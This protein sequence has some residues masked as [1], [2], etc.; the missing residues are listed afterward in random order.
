MHHADIGLLADLDSDAFEQRRR[1]V[2][3]RQQAQRLVGEYVAHR[4]VRFARTAPVGGQA[5][6]PVV[7]LGIEIVEI[8]EAA[9]GEEGAR[10][11]ADRPLDPALLVAARHR[12]RPRFE[13]ILASKGEQ[14]RVEADC[15]AAPFQHR[16][17]EIVDS[18]TRGTPPQAVKAPTWS[19]TKFSNQ[20]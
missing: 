20:Q 1:V 18:S 3:Q 5:A 12:D 8:G 7:G 15:I 10:H 17:L 2:G 13:A 11:V 14:A 9:R 16:T 19:R 4:A 6:T